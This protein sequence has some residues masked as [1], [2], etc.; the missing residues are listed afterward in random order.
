MSS[1]LSD[2][3]GIH[4][5][6]H[7]HRRGLILSLNFAEGQVPTV[8]NLLNKLFQNCQVGYFS[9]LS[10]NQN[11]LGG[12]MNYIENWLPGTPEKEVEIFTFLIELNF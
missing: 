9:P 11:Y 6:I 10:L 7:M 5:R 12:R 1:T 8:S 4:A 2:N 3:T